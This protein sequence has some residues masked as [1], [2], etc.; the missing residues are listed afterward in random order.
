MLVYTADFVLP[1]ASPLIKDGAVAIDADRIALVGPRAVVL[2]SAGEAAETR[3]LGRMAILPGLVNAHC[4]L[5]LSWMGE[6]RPAGGSYARWVRGLL[7]RRDR[8]DETVAVKAA[9]TALEAMRKRGTVA[10]GDISNDV[11]MVRLLARSGMHGIAFHELLGLRTGDAEGLLEQAAARLEQ[12]TSDLEVAAATDR[13]RVAL[14]PHAPHTASVA[15]L[16]ALAGRAAATGDQLSIHLA[17]S[18]DETSM[19]LD[20]SGPLPELFRERGFWDE[21]WSPPGHSPVVYADRMGLLTRR[22]LAVHCVEMRQ[23]DHSKLQTRGVTVVTCPRSNRWIGG[24]VAPIPKLLGEG[25]P[26]A[27]GTDSLASAPDVDLFAEIAA[28]RE[29][30]GTLPPAAALRMATLNGARA[31]GLDDR[32]GTIETGKLAELLAVPVPSADDNPLPFLCSNPETVHRLSEAPE[33][34][35]A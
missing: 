17:E 35:E 21:T 13:L 28:L 2:K 11:W 15:L 23:Q 4:H 20:G 9:E 29:E 34:P 12:I 7:E 18:E 33:S 27:L 32:L 30:H 5:E 8:T 24:G 22:T 31:L 6:D 19:L 14:T 1:V 10:V 25:I 26:V 16:R 3:D